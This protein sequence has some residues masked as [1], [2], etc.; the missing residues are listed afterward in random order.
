METCYSN[1]KFY[2]LLRLLF[3]SITAD[4]I[5]IF[6]H[7]S[8]FYR[9]WTQWDLLGYPVVLVCL[10]AHNITHTFRWQRWLEC[11]L[12]HLFQSTMFVM[13]CVWSYSRMAWYANRSSGVCCMVWSWGE[14]CLLFMQLLRGKSNNNES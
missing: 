9:T 7:V 11:F 8:R 4:I 6:P 1:V 2:D 12:I 3:S 13:D 5:L 14:I 10:Y